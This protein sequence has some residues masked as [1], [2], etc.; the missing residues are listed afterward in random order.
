M[1]IPGAFFFTKSL[2]LDMILNEVYS[3][4]VKLTAARRAAKGKSHE[5]DKETAFRTF[6]LAAFDGL[7]LV[8]G[9]RR[10]MLRH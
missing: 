3:F 2:R 6:P 4:L 8:F 9:S 1:K 5:T 7:N 10:T